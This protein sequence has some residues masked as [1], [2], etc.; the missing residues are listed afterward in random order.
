MTIPENI[1]IL[2]GII[3]AVLI[4]GVVI[5]IR[6][7]RVKKRVHQ[8]GQAYFD[9]ERQLKARFKSGLMTYEDYRREHEA[10]VSEMRRHSRKFTD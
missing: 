5:S 2:P 9:K 7:R 4:I 8:M 3:I 1:F 6:L 10:L